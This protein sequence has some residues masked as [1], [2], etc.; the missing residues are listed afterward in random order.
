MKKGILKKLSWFL[1]IFAM[2]ITTV[3]LTGPVETKAATTDDDEWTTV[4]QTLNTVEN[5]YAGVE[6]KIDITLT[7]NDGVG[8]Y[9]M[10]DEPSSGMINV[11]DK[12]GNKLDTG[13]FSSYDFSLQT[14]EQYVVYGYGYVPYVDL[15]EGDYS[16]GYTFDTDTQFLTVIQQKNVVATMSQ[17]KMTLTAGFTD[18]L[19]VSGGAVK[20]WS[21]KNKAI[22]TVDKKGKVTAK[23]TGNTTIVA[24]LK[25]G[26]TLTCKVKVVANKYKDTKLTTG[27]CPYGDVYCA[28]YAASFD[29][30]GN[31]VIKAQCVNRY[32]H[33]VTGFQNIKITVIDQNGKKVATHK[34]SSL[35]ANISTQSAKTLT[36]TIKKSE[37]KKKKIDLRNSKIKLNGKYKYS[38]YY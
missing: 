23:K 16:I 26:K 27:N 5:G 11:Y 18:K 15:K 7:E 8:I 36:F 9:I 4:Y 28:A 30:S 3:L 31:L 19:S 38:Y 24:T 20:S 35:S 13:Y 17:T 6:K 34:I 32:Y 37:L 22:A 14:V 2:A 1:L 25:N 29:K 12:A 33:K 21:S 10:V